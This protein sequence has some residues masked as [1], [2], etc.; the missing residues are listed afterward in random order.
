MQGGCAVKLRTITLL[1]L[2]LVSVLPA[3]ARADSIDVPAVPST[4]P[5]APPAPGG[6]LSLDLAGAYELALARNLDLAV[7]RYNLAAA[8]A[9]IHS[10][11]GLFDPGFSLGVNGDFAESPAATALEG[12]LITESRNTRFSA[13][14]DQLLPT[15]TYLRLDTT[16]RRGETNSTFFFV[17]PRWNMDVSLF[18]R[19]PLLNGFGT[20]FNRAGIV[21]AKNN[22]E[23]SAEA[24]EILVVRTLQVVENSYWDLVATRRAVAVSE[25][26][27]ELAQR[28][29]AETEERVK[30]GT[31]A[32]IDT[33]QSEAGVAQRRQT[34]IAARNGSSNTEDA[35]KAVLGFDSPDEWLVEIDTVES[36]EFSPLEVDLREAIET[37]LERRPEIREKR[38]ELERLEYN[39]KLARHDVLPSL[40]VEG[41]YGF[42]GI[43]GPVR[44]TG[45]GGQEIIIDGGF[46]DAW[47]QVKNGEF[48]NWRLGANF[49][50][51][52]GNNDAQGR[53]A[54]RRFEKQRGM[55]EMAALK[56]E[57]IRQVRV[58]VR[59]LEDGAAQVD[60]SLAARDLAERNLEAEETKF[61]NGL[62]TNYQVLEIQEDLARARLNLIQAYLDYR[63]AI[64]G[65]RVATGT[66]LDSLNV[67]II[68]PG[69]PD[70][71]HD[72]W[73]DVEWLQLADLKSSSGLVTHPAEAVTQE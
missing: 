55:V 35:L 68:D 43:G 39:E 49:S 26:S 33:V 11:T 28:L 3:T 27:L 36:Y 24:F 63:K 8:G 50:V 51:P 30:V 32:P 70:V 67:D 56:Q 17:N 61:A 14:L 1:F 46:Q 15:G 25:Q 42:S 52:I 72:Y 64:A 5:G 58:S 22:R 20:L 48:D 73:G 31:S 12:A 71:P 6:V 38:L 2:G 4:V 40:D 9:N 37:A 54:Q 53:L 60:A 59:A 34:L 65:Y 21:I 57:I 13:Q 23:R 10:N 18:I 29:L 66:L 44:V 47:T 41:A 69:A 19:Q 16:A 45:P 62:S 7:G